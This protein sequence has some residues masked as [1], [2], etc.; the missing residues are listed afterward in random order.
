VHELF[1][2][3]VTPPPEFGKKCRQCSLIDSCMPNV[4]DRSRSVGRYVRKLYSEL[5]EEEM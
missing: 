1:A 4:V 2:S 3:G 5:S